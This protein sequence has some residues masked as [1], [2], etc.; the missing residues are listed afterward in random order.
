[1][2]CGVV[3]EHDISY[4]ILFFIYFGRKA[5]SLSSLFRRLTESLRADGG[6]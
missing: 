4:F 5:V 6:R 3:V 1:M 2:E